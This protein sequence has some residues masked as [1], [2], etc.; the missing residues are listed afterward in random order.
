MTENIL[1]LEQ[2]ANAFLYQSTDQPTPNTI[3]D[4]L[5]DEEKTAKKNKNSVTLKQLEGSWRLFFV[6]GTKKTRDRAGIILGSGKYIP[7]WVKIYLLYSQNHNNE[8]GTIGNSVSLG[9]LKLLLNGPMKILPNKNIVVFDFT[10]L[11]IQVLGQKIFSG[12]VRGDQK[13]EDNFTQASIQKQAFFSYFAI[14]DK[15]IAA[16]GKGGGLAIWAKEEQ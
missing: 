15:I 16:R 3:V 7:K 13:N 14:S 9:T 2:A 1:V 6:T 5:L 12:Y 8:I 10:R 4:A 11:T